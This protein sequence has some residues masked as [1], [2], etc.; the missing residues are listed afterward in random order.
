VGG[1]RLGA[2]EAAQPL[3]VELPELLGLSSERVDVRELLEALVLPEAVLASI[4]G[5]TRFGRDPGPG[6]DDGELGCREVVG[7]ARDV[8]AAVD[9]RR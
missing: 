1:V 7:D 5:Q 9:V 6:E 2:V 4:V 8:R 3:G